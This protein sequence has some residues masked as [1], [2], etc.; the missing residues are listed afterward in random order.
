M[1][2]CL[3]WFIRCL[4]AALL[5]HTQGCPRGCPPFVQFA[6]HATV[7]AL[8]GGRV[9][10]GGRLL[11]DGYLSSIEAEEELRR[12][13]GQHQDSVSPV[14]QGN[15]S[16]DELQTSAVGASFNYASSDVLVFLHIQ[17]T[18]GTTFERYLVRQ[19]DLPVPCKCQPKRKRCL[20]S[21]PQDINSS[22]RSSWLFSRF[23]T[24]WNC[25]L[26]SDWTELVVS[27]CVDRYFD[28]REKGHSKRR[29]FIT[30][31]LR[32]P[33]ARFISEFRHVQRGA[34]WQ[35]S[36]H[37]CNGRSPTIEELPPCFEPSIG[38]TGVTLDDFMSCKS[39]LAFNRQTR[40]LADLTTVHCYNESAMPNE[41]RRTV[42][43]RS[44]KENL[45]KMA[46]FGLQEEMRKSQYLFEKTFGLR[47]NKPMV[48]MEPQTSP[49]EVSPEDRQRIAD[50]NQLDMEIYHFAKEVFLRRFE[51][52]RTG[53]SIPFDAF[54]S[55]FRNSC[56]YY[57][58]V[59]HVMSSGECASVPA[60][61]FP[62][63]LSMSTKNSHT[64][65]QIVTVYNPYE[66]DLEYKVLSTA[67]ALYS[68]Q[69]SVG[70]L[71][72]QSLV[73][74]VIRRNSSEEDGAGAAC[75]DKFRVQVR[76]LTKPLLVGHSD[77]V[78]FVNGTAS[79][80]AGACEQQ[81]SGR[82][83][84]VPKVASSSHRTTIA[85]RDSATRF[86][87]D[88]RS[89]GFHWLLMVVGAVCIVCLWTPYA[90]ERTEAVPSWYPEWLRLTI[91]QKLVSAYVLGL[92]TVIV[93]QV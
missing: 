75:V 92:L 76:K 62:S 69:E 55:F 8:F 33:V 28:S 34:T 90:E 11:Q 79:T 21:R 81:P 18:G 71:K 77:I 46:F 20:C 39:N 25:G 26:H 15:V 70:R 83:D 48:D 40:M 35:S 9:R 59:G 80:S 42:L 29:Y 78:V 12:A 86:R 88:Q 51:L 57:R 54:A 91:P 32:E 4:F 64:L 63:T 56:A 16:F 45:M 85:R 72:P 66:F 49:D 84:E 67:P 6:I 87:S 13:G 30:T 24:G 3:Y 68:V 27:G 14:E 89:D 10:A 37:M 93:L 58:D 52:A 43:V 38:W 36:A 1:F 19:L 47:F 50:F 60:F 31:F 2:H 73:D 44:A 7:P 41:L 23:S 74:I 22:R 5:R 17:K 61:V 65:R 53:T 82:V